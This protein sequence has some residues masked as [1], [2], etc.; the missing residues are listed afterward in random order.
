MAGLIGIGLSGVL[1]HQSALNTTGNNIVNANTPGYSR[2]E[3]QFETQPGRTTGSG[4]IGSGVSI[5]DIR[6][7][8]DQYLVEQVRADTALHSEQS[9]LNSEL[10][11]LDDLL[12]G[13]D[14]GLSQ[15]LNNFFASLQN[16]AENPGSLPQR[17]LVL[18]EAQGIVNRFQALQ[19]EFVQQREL[20]KS[21]MNEGVQDVNTLLK[22]IA[23]LNVA[24]SEA[25]G[26]A[27]GI[28][29]NELLDKRD[30][31]LRQ[32][33]EQVRIR[34]VPAGGSQVNVL[35]NNG[36]ALVVGG[37]ASE[38]GTRSNADDPMALEFTLTQS[39][40]T[41]VIDEQITGGKLGGLRR[42]EQEALS[43]AFDEL[44]RVA[45]VLA[46]RM[47]HQ[48][49][50]GMDLEGDL[51]G[52]FFS[53]INSPEIQRARVIASENNLPPK[54]GVLG[55]EITDSS[56]LPA[57]SWTLQMTGDDGRSYELIDQQSGKI[58]NQGRLPDVLPAEIS[59]PGFN[60]R[61][62]SGTFSKGDRFQIQPTRQAAA[63]IE[64]QVEREEDLAFASPVRAEASDGNRGNAQINQ[65]LMLD[66]R[67]PLTNAPLPEFNQR[68]ELSPPLMVRFTET[69]GVMGYEVLDA[70]DPNNPVSL[71]PV[72]TGTFQP[73]MSN[74]LFSEDPA[75][76]NYRG[77]QFEIGGNP[78][79]GDSFMISYN[80]NGVSD[81][82]NGELLAGM[83]TRNTMNGG[84]QSFT[85]G[86]AG[87][88]EAVGVK[89]R[90]AQMDTDSGMTLLQ[91]S[92]SQRQSVSGVNLDEEAGK[93][94]QYQAAYN[95]SARVMG[96]AQELFNTLLTTF[97]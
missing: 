94:I 48:H 7:L 95:A 25:P 59:M 93:L 26:T 9:T 66:V 50:I 58:V 34:V 38:L 10:S 44:G 29:P 65:G 49:Q 52:V 42:F 56:H 8:A 35:L 53:D 24:I 1:G 84:T 6:R 54:D 32:L 11:R 18:S 77:F 55:V 31:A 46:D 57:G 61:V 43:P 69:A 68:G 96:V 92:T 15:T 28:M 40:R 88:V 75:D 97:R 17:Q 36:Q 91:Q 72:T 70:T 87:L 27:Q 67:N 90:Q 16:A 74:K 3:V 21:Q 37:N 2:Q 82:R 33:S 62:E 63:N 51:G 47:N 12:G 23:D 71:I 78:A 85:E 79:H 4:R 19:Q 30:E 13:E 64:L 41:M 22:G 89:T 60:V 76:A 73:G 20:V 86:Y 39:G 5:S 80:T 81:N 83:A 14:T 45:V